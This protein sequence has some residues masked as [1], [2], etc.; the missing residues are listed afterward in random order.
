MRVY[1]SGG[2]QRQRFSNGNTQCEIATK[3][4]SEF[5]DVEVV[6]SGK[7]DFII[8]DDLNSNG[9]SASALRTGGKVVTYSQFLRHMR[10]SKKIGKQSRKKSLHK[11]WRANAEALEVVEQKMDKLSLNPQQDTKQPNAVLLFAKY[12]TYIYMMVTNS[13]S[14]QTVIDMMKP[15]LDGLATLLVTEKHATNVSLMQRAWYNYVAEIGIIQNKVNH[16][17]CSTTLDAQKE[18]TLRS[19]AIVTVYIKSNSEILNIMDFFANHDRDVIQ[20]VV[21][22]SS[23]QNDTGVVTSF[24]KLMTSTLEFAMSIGKEST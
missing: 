8:V 15:T 10:N 5:P 17:T 23:G 22:A 12:V 14:M 9:A 4:Q 6:K 16:G 19:N 2:S 20:L 11:D 18:L 7:T 24:D 13:S 3:I 21:D 1:I